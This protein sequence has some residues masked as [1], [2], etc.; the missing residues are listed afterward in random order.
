[1]EATSLA[2]LGVAAFA[3]S[4]LSAIVGMAGGIV[5]L[6]VMLLFLEPLAAIPLHGAIQLLSNGS[7]AALQR[8]FVDRSVLL[9]FGV[10]LVP[11]GLL[12]LQVATALPPDAIRV[13]IGVFVL[14]ATWAPGALLLGIHPETTSP[15]ARFLALGGVAGALNVTLGAVGPLLAPFYLGLGLSRQAMVGT[16]AACQAL[17]HA[18]KIALF[19]LAGFAFAPHVP[20]LVVAGT[21]VVAGTW[22][23]TRLL[24]RIDERTFQWLYKVVLTVIAVRLLVR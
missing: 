18:V 17:G 11:G 14:L 22:V 4:V 1:L 2:W 12:G 9:Y 21:G 3:T 15:R 24:D 6:A 20:L 10:L 16:K 13:L 19:G 23:G 5:L 8:R 7:R